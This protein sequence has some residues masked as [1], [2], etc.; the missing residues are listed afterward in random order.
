MDDYDFE[1]Y[2]PVFFGTSM[3][4][5]YPKL[6]EKVGEDNGETPL[7]HVKKFEKAIALL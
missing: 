7:E 4:K 5:K 3:K 1:N 2:R 6:V